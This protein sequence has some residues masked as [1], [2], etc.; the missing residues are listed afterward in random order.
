MIYSSDPRR[1]HSAPSE[2]VSGA[3]DHLPAV[4]EVVSALS[5]HV[6]VADEYVS[7]VCCVHPFT[8]D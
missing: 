5:D 3:Y 6:S 4:A 8:M 7:A 1:D 2:V